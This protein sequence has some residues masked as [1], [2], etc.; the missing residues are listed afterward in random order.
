MFKTTV[1]L[2]RGAT[3]SAERDFAD[4]NALRLLDQQIRDATN[5]LERAKKA[6]RWKEWRR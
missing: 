5:A 1:T 3:A 4:R 2:I 6:R